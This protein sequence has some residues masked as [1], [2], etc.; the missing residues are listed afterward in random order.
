MNEIAANS[1][2]N[3]PHPGLVLDRLRDQFGEPERGSHED[4]VSGLVSTILSQNTTD[5]NTER[6]FQG[7]RKRFPDWNAVVEAE[8]AEVAD[9]IRTG[10]LADQKAPR[11]QKALRAIF[12]SQGTY[13]L[14][15]LADLPVRD[16]TG[17]LTSLPGVGPKTA[18]CVLLFNLERDVL[19]VDTHV[20]RVA[21]RL[22]WIPENATAEQA[23]P[24]LEELI[25]P[26]ERFAAH[27]LLIWHG[28]KTCK[29]R[30]PRCEHCIIGDICP[31]RTL[32][33]TGGDSA[34]ARR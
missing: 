24:L 16:A 11:I 26:S 15:F 12:D 8:T 14:G 27:L 17:W 13:D 30:T 33:T 2:L 34:G 18:A 25:E 23:Q 22:K 9:A 29:A 6:A 31:S 7:L 1:T 5:S 3:P 28:R 19:P 21:R 20:H 10:G 32:F 4:P